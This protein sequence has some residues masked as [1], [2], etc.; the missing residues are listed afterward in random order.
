MTQR[1]DTRPRIAVVDYGKGNLTS[2]ERGLALA[3]GASFVTADPAAIRSAD[4]VVLP[5]VGAFAEAIA[6]LEA[7]GQADA[8]RGSIADGRPFLGVCLGMQLLMDEGDEGVDRPVA[9]LG[10]VPGR[11]V[12]IR[13]AMKVPH[14]GWNL[15]QP[16]RPDRLV[17]TNGSSY[18][19][20]T[21]SYVCEPRD[22]AVVTSVVEHGVDLVASLRLGK[23]YGVQFHPEKSS[24]LGLALLRS[25]VASIAE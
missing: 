23:V 22:E 3:G 20:F 24:T 7:S 8:I 5:G 25:F 4:A 19:Y 12:R 11:V 21:H 6:Y 9:G 15:V 13:S 16:T 10:V 14:V 2:M 1:S 17:D 18:Y